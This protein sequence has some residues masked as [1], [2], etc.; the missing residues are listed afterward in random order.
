MAKLNLINQLMVVYDNITDP[1]E[2]YKIALRVLNL[3]RETPVL[4]GESMNFVDCYELS[5]N[6]LN[7]ECELLQRLNEMQSREEAS[8]VDR[9]YR[10]MSVLE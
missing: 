5:C 4:D 6:A 10:K 1:V 3:I 9:I 8:E 7:R 2:I